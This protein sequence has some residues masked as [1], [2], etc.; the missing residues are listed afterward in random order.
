MEEQTQHNTNIFKANEMHFIP[1]RIVLQVSQE[2]SQFSVCS[3]EKNV[4]WAVP[5]YL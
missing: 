3:N 2:V 4:Q 5:P 1:L